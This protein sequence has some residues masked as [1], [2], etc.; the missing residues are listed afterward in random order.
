[1]LIEVLGVGFSLFALSRVFLRYREGKFSTTMLIVW[2]MAWLAVIAFIVS[3][4]IFEF[5][6][7]AAG[8][9][10]PL[11]LMLPVAVLLSYYLIFRLY[12]HMEDMKTDMA[13]LARAFA[14]KEM[15]KD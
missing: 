10:R 6:S 11:D 3:L 14:L 15:E 2:S 9:E 12:I 7:R 4:D 1:M 13:K 8:I 5:M